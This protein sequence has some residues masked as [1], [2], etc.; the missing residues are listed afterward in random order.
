MNRSTVA[1]RWNLDLIEEHYQRWRDDPASVDDIL[2]D[3]LRRLRAGSVRRR[4]RPPTEADLDA[5]AGPGRRS[6]A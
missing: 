1:N 4:A 6:P 5:G 2:A 3:L